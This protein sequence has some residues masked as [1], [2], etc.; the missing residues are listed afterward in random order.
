MSCTIF[1]M[2]LRINKKSQAN[3]RGIM[4][5]TLQGQFKS[6][7]AKSCD[8]HQ[9]DTLR[10]LHDHRALYSIN[11]LPYATKPAQKVQRNFRHIFA[12]R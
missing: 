4:C 7:G 8:I 10:L 6:T 3:T 11:R 5:R 12:K 2:F 1:F 9:G